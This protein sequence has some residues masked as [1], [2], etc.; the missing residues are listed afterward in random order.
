M[1]PTFNNSVNVLQ[2][3]TRLVFCFMNPQHSS[4]FLKYSDIEHFVNVM[5]KNW[6]QIFC[7]FPGI[8][9]HPSQ[10]LSSCQTMQYLSN[11]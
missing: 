2:L 5:A 3:D 9:F 6:L 4:F 10:L 1:H 8:L 11:L 7:F